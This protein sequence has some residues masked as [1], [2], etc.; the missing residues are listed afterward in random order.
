MSRS[1]GLDQVIIQL[2]LREHMQFSLVRE[3]NGL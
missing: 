1:I 3:I 2:D